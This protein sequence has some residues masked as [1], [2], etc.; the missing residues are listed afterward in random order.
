MKNTLTPLPHRFTLLKGTL[1]LSLLASTSD[2]GWGMCPKLDPDLSDSSSSSSSWETLSDQS[3]ETTSRGTSMGADS[4][5]N[6]LDESPVNP[7]LI[8]IKNI[9]RLIH[10]IKNGTISTREFLNN[11]S[12][13]IDAMSV[14]DGEFWN[15]FNPTMQREGQSPKELMSARFML[16][17]LHQALKEGF[18]SRD[19]ENF[20]SSRLIKALSS[21][22][23][24]LRELY[25][26]EIAQR[27]LLL[28]ME[29][30]PLS[31]LEVLVADHRHLK[32]EAKRFINQL[33]ES[34]WL[35]R[36]DRFERAMEYLNNLAIQEA[37]CTTQ[38]VIAHER[39]KI[40]A[41][42]DGQWARIKAQERFASAPE[43][44]LLIGV[45]YEYESL[46]AV[47]QHIEWLKAQRDLLLNGDLSFS[48]RVLVQSL[49]MVSE[50]LNSIQ[51]SLDLS[52]DEIL[53]LKSLIKSI[54]NLLEHEN[55]P[56]AEA[57]FSDAGLQ[58]VF[59][60]GML[61][62]FFII[63][64]IIKQRLARLGEL[65]S[66]T[67]S[68]V[69]HAWSHLTSLPREKDS[70]DS[71]HENYDTAKQ[72]FAH[73]I[74]QDFAWQGAP[75]RT[76]SF[77]R[78]YLDA[79]YPTYPLLNP[80]DINLEEEKKIIVESHFGG[81]HEQKWNGKKT[82]RKN[83]S[84][85][86][87]SKPLSALVQGI[88]T[89][90]KE[91]E[92][93]LQATSSGMAR[94]TNHYENLVD[95]L[96]RD[97]GH[98]TYLV[99]LMVEIYRKL[100]LLLDDDKK[101]N[102]L[103]M[104]PDH[105]FIP[106]VSTLSNLRD[107]RN[108]AIHDLWRK[109]LRGLA[110]IAIQMRSF[111]PLLREAF[112]FPPEA[113]PYNDVAT[114]NLWAGILDLSIS[115]EEVLTLCQQGANPNA[116]DEHGQTLLNYA[117]NQALA[118][119]DGEAV[120]YALLQCGADVN[121]CD[122]NGV[123][124]IH[125]AATNDDLHMI[126]EFKDRGAIPYVRD[127]QGNT[128]ADHGSDAAEP[129]MDYHL[130]H[131]E[132]FYRGLE[133]DRGHRTFDE[134]A[135]EENDINPADGGVP[136]YLYDA[137][138]NLPLI[139]A[140]QENA[141]LDILK[142]LLANGADVNQ[143][144]FHGMT[145]LRTLLDQSDPI[146]VKLL[147]L[148]LNQGA[149]LRTVRPISLDPSL[150][151][152][153]SKLMLHEYTDQDIALSLQ[154]SLFF[155]GSYWYICA[156]FPNLEGLDPAISQVLFQQNK[157]QYLFPPITR[158]HNIRP[159]T[160]LTNKIQQFFASFGSFKPKNFELLIP[161]NPGG[162]WVTLHVQVSPNGVTVEY[163]DS[164]E[165]SEDI[166]NQS[167]K[168]IA[169]ERTQLLRNLLEKQ[170]GKVVFKYKLAR[171]QQDDFACGALTVANILDI[172][173]GMPPSP[174]VHSPAD[175]LQERKLQQQR[176]RNIGREFEFQAAPGTQASA[177]PRKKTGGGTLSPTPHENGHNV[178][179]NNLNTFVSYGE[180][181]PSAHNFPH[182]PP[183][184]GQVYISGEGN[185][186]LFNALSTALDPDRRLSLAGQNPREVRRWAGNLLLEALKAIQ[187]GNITNP[188]GI[189]ALL[190]ADL[191]Q[192]LTHASLYTGNQLLT[193]LLQTLT[194]H[195]DTVLFGTLFEISQA[196]EDRRAELLH[197]FL[198]NLQGLLST[199]GLIAFLRA[200][201]EQSIMGRT[202]YEGVTMLALLAQVL[203][204]QIVLYSSQSTTSQV[205][206]TQGLPIIHLYHT[207][208][209]GT[210]PNAA[211]HFN[212]LV[213][214]LP[215]PQSAVTVSTV[216]SST[217][218]TP[219]HTILQNTVATAAPV[220]SSIL[221]VS[222]PGIG[223]VLSGSRTP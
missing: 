32:R 201:I 132:A 213:N 72:M 77:L 22:D 93:F 199:T 41:L 100:D 62:D 114:N 30:L 68:G 146:D 87:S 69:E 185:A 211:N 206:G 97:L 82:G 203:Q 3:D 169:E 120:V 76:L 189:A 117:V 111:Y 210:A 141:T 112:S 89:P 63:Q 205:F 17:Y 134:W 50:A 207:S 5:T 57:L 223:S 161:F 130:K 33:Q 20:L 121:L 80:Q 155:P 127:Y 90:L 60:T 188:Q 64:K 73:A 173:N 108:F 49:Y 147:T 38:S 34:L 101:T 144:D 183:G 88:L 124:P 151:A 157:Q 218:T 160:Q 61:E 182:I 84:T 59:F 198:D 149:H 166:I 115:A 129:V 118:A 31:M 175:I 16:A 47:S 7:D 26:I 8:R 123:Y 186:C 125:I 54:R 204:R 116:C 21:F 6:S 215:A 122:V 25:E 104:L 162:H 39:K 150:T 4:D 2:Q 163:I 53:I 43:I 119:T 216:V 95:L 103:S 35:L 126:E 172:T 136:P 209:D 113:N 178:M 138:G 51:T 221:S 23:S 192:Y 48:K 143:P 135:F 167:I 195:E 196:Q 222:S 159:E 158:D 152:E 170:F 79:N 65:I 202:S 52:S 36:P 13:Q 46:E 75:L 131:D 56:K 168:T 208:Y 94:Q 156:Q 110:G 11:I 139:L 99:H 153:E 96:H 200:Y 190:L 40:K 140:L 107:R 27:E 70:G 106:F 179:I 128:Y 180:I 58:K 19:V 176:L 74:W 214:T 212:L 177:K 165:H 10:E 15:R 217:A 142:K 67:G 187:P 85:D 83:K 45:I 78:R 154:S 86:T 1:I 71:L 220:A 109:D 55:S 102:T 184:M 66:M 174:K 37:D 181:L 133:T 14:L 28:A 24:F 164:L 148:L 18:M 12:W 145:P 194:P 171:I 81:W 191:Q 44:Q 137:E 197:H 105:L 219:L 29:A 42:R 9:Q 193:G 92:K 98:K 91:L